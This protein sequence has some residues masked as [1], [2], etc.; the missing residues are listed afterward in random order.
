MIEQKESPAF[1]GKDFGAGAYER[2]SGQV[3]GELDPADPRNSIITDIQFAPRNA[4]GM[5]EYSATFTLLKPMDTSKA[6][7]VLIYDVPNRGSR[8][9]LGAIQ[10]GEPGD[11]FLFRRG[12]AILS[13]G[14]QGDVLPSPGVQSLL[15]PVARNPDGSSIT[16][17]VLV[18]FSDLPPGTT[19][20]PVTA[21]LPRRPYLAASLDTTKATLT[22]RASEEGAILP[23]APGDWA[24]ADCTTRAFPGLPD[25][26]HICLKKGFE[27][28]FLYE[29]TY[30]AKDPLVLG[31]GFAATRDTVSFFRREAKDGVGAANPLSGQIKHVVALGISQSGNFVK[32][33]VHL[34]FNQD[35]QGQR[36]WDGA[37]DH[38]AA[39]Q[40]P[41]N[42]RF[43]VPGGSA[44][45]YEP[46]SEA[47]L[48]W[49]DSND[50]VRGRKADGMLRR[51]GL[52]STC[53]KIFETFGSAEFWG[54]KMSPGLV[55]T[56]AVADIPLPPAVRRYYFPGTTHGGGRGGF[57][58]ASPARGGRCLLPDNPN[59]ESDTMRALLDA[60]VAW[61]TKDVE[62]PASRYPRIEQGQLVSGGH[63]EM[64][65]PVIPGYPLPDQLLNTFYDYDFGPG[66]LYNDLSGVISLQPPVRKQAI[67]MLVPKVDIDGNEMTGVP[68]VQHQAPLGSYLGWNVTARGF[69][70][71][72]GC[73]FAGGFLPFAATRA[74]R[75]AAGDPR[76]SLEERYPT[77][78]SF[79]E[80]VRTAA[81]QL[82]RDRFLLQEDA[83]R[84]IREATVS[85]VGR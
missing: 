81:V 79:V 60:L 28:G 3:F 55:G 84:L 49:A 15:A 42:F 24:F 69:Q 25:P 71:G 66:F 52:S 80:R 59:P 38:I 47:V 17:P 19:S 6:S 13:S 57:N 76:P 56:D 73:G 7:G 5:V 63:R 40:T 32:S 16:G 9:L 1:A 45:M 75:L 21:L 39:R 48:W 51:C 65:F 54:L 53:P 18:R 43:A 30:T 58:I 72:R 10:G 78:D 14:W 64:G 36:V 20:M 4:R 83:D 77:H 8:L 62:P 34:G 74:E 37:D 11:G 33:F 82:V 2:L 22:K 26:G 12:H 27:P 68:S 44:G 29:L 70:Q 85:A 61:V 50:P 23:L 67:R 35:E 41:L 31:I 46:G